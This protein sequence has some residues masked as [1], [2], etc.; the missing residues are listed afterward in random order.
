MKSNEQKE[1]D[2]RLRD[3]INA[4]LPDVPDHL[5]ENIR[6]ELDRGRAKSSETEMQR[7]IRRSHG[8]VWWIAASLLILLG[9]SWLIG[10]ND[11]KI[12]YLRGVADPSEKLVDITDLDGENPEYPGSTSADNRGSGGVIQAQP[13]VNSLAEDLQSITQFLNGLALPAKSD[14][15]KSHLSAESGEHPNVTAFASNESPTVHLDP[16]ER[17]FASHES[18][19]LLGTQANGNRQLDIEAPI[20]LD[21]ESLISIVPDIVFP[22]N[23]T[24]QVSG[25]SITPANPTETMPKSALVVPRLLNMVVAQ[26]DRRPEKI[27]SFSSDEE[28][29]LKIVI[30]H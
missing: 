7:E 13:L 20:S 8:G 23:A 17:T 21:T 14:N 16:E 18:S 28:G 9:G 3:K 4:C 5:W 19:K 1:S 12:T 2:R 30:N 24:L 15:S 11:T 10:L 25:P 22:T 6:S 26:L 27:L 29:S